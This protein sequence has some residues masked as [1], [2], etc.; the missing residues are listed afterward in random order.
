MAQEP[1]SLKWRPPVARALS[2]RVTPASREVPYE[3]RE[4]IFVESRERDASPRRPLTH[5]HSSAE[6]TA[7]AIH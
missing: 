7:A 1:A 2:F 5:V 4:D 3:A 6:V